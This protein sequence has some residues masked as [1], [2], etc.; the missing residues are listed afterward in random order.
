MAS[1]KGKIITV[2]STKGGVGKTIFTINLAG[3]F[4][5]LN[6]RVLIIDLDLYSGGIAVSLNV[7]SKKDIYNLIDDLN[8]NRFTEFNDYVSKYND[9]IDVLSCPKD[10]RQGSKISSKYVEIVLVNAIS[11]YDIVLID[12]S[13]ILNDVNLTA[14]DKTDDILLLLSNDP[15]DLKNMKSLIAIFKDSEIDNYYVVLN[16]AINTDKDFFTPFDI[17][18]IIK[19]NIDYTIGQ[20][21]HMNNIDHYVINGEIPILNKKVKSQ[22]KKEVEKFLK[23]AKRLIGKDGDIND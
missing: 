15:I 10:P 2:F 21:F 20:Q 7:D 3:T 17:K 14:L 4:H 13:H 23:I 22:K 6:K 1:K 9:N 11:R 19:T 16:N 8:N 5:N 12:T 18:N